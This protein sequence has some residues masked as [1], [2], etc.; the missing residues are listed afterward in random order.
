MAEPTERGSE[1]MDHPREGMR[2]CPTRFDKEQTLFAH[3]ITTAMCQERQRQHYHKCPT[4]SHN[5]VRAALGKQLPSAGKEA[6]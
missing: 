3:M 1:P 5:N 2:L 4:C 6:V